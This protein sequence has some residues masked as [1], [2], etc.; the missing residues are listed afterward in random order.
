MNSEQN[1]QKT[2]HNQIIKC[3]FPRPSNDEEEDLF[4]RKIVEKYRGNI[5][6]PMILSQDPQR[7]M[8]QMEEAFDKLKKKLDSWNQNEKKE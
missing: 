5:A 8:E 3:T 2:H 7:R 6:E 4:L 1:Q